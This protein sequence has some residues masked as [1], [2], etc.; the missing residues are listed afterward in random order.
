MRYDAVKASGITQKESTIDIL[1][2][3]ISDFLVLLSRRPL[4][5][6]NSM[7]IPVMLQ[8]V[9]ELEHVGDQTESILVNLGRKKEEKLLFSNVAMTEIRNLARKVEE[10]LV[11]A[12]ECTENPAADVTDKGREIRGEVASMR[13]V[14]LNGHIKRLSAGKCTVRAGIIYA[15]M[16][17]AFVKTADSCLTIIETKREF[18]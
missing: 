2:R 16:I 1:Q 18:S 11:L 7:E 13:E 12:V 14:M 17:S 5:P 10:L 8:I 4:P 6:E 3:E 15:D 9:S